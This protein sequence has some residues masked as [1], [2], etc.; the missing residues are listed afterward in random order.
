MLL[1]LMIES[2][3][4]VIQRPPSTLLDL[5]IAHQKN[6]GDQHEPHQATHPEP[7]PHDKSPGAANLVAK[8][9]GRLHAVRS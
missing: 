6:G 1:K 3:K 4:L 5:S 2:T 8:L 7:E 9:T